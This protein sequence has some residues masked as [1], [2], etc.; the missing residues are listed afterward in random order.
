MSYVLSMQVRSS[1][2]GCDSH[3]AVPNIVF[4]RSDLG[5]TLLNTAVPL[6]PRSPLDGRTLSGD[7][8]PVRVGF[9][10]NAGRA[11]TEVK[12]SLSINNEGDR[13][14][15]RPGYDRVDKL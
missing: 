13:G 4:T 2:G 8:S 15:S 1:D 12:A 3:K 6:L 10:G 7:S 11:G 9:E 5:R 14:R